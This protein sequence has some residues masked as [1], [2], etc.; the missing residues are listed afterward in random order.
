MLR[1]QIEQ[2]LAA[3]ALEG[4]ETQFVDDFADNAE[5][6]LGYYRSVY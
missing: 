1:Q 6:I 5:E 3:D 2:Q 4:Q